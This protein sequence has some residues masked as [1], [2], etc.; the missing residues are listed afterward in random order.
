MSVRCLRI[1]EDGLLMDTDPREVL[2]Y[3]AQA[4]PHWLDIQEDNP[5]VIAEIMQPLALDAEF[6]QECASLDRRRV[7]VSDGAASLAFPI[8][9]RDQ[10]HPAYL[11]IVAIPNL[12]VTIHRSRLPAL[13]HVR[14]DFSYKAQL[15]APTTAAL[16]CEIFEAV[17]DG[18]ILLG[19]EARDQVNE[20]AMKMDERVESVDISELL[21]LKHEIGRLEIA[22][23]DQLY[24]VAALMQ[25]KA[26][27]LDIEEQRR[28]F[29][30]FE[31]ELETALHSGN[32]LERRLQDL[33][34]YFVTCLQEKTNRRLNIL[35]MIQ[36]I[37]VPMTVIA[38]IYGMNFKDMPELTS[39][40][41]YPVVLLVMAGIAIVELYLFY[42]FGWFDFLQSPSSSDG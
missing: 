42:R 1:T 40:F 36:S 20:L 25:I 14:E 41:G 9:S 8:H 30:D 38:G 32:R 2:S 6:V 13:A 26:S 23:E 19:F 39:P 27:G 33:H 28:D 7:A 31:H 37:F 35:T 12:V 5:D 18:H 11:Q 17:F 29:R 22:F 16:M 21:T 3:S 15:H 34:Q 24:C 4:I 10:M